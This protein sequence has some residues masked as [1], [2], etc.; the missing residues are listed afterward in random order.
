MT[1]VLPIAYSRSLFMNRRTFVGNASLLTASLALPSAVFAAAAPAFPVVRPAASQRRFRS[2]AVEATITEF[3]KK[4]KDPELGLRTA[5]R[6]PSIP[7]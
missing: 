3:K 5:F 4:V 6:A 2:K 7:P 1:D